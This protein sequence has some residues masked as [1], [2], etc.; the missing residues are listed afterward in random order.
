[1]RRLRAALLLPVRSAPLCST[2]FWRPARGIGWLARLARRVRTI[3]RLLRLTIALALLLAAVLLFFAGFPLLSG[4]PLLPWLLTR[5]VSHLLQTAAQLFGLSQ[6]SFQVRITALPTVER[7]LGFMHAIAQL[8]ESFGHGGLPR[9][10][11]RSHS[12]P[13]HF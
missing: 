6:G 12:S 4:L 13:H 11:I 9:H 7:L 8:V 1:M 3:P 2:R 5:R 10:C